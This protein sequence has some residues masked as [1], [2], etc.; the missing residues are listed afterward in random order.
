MRR[1]RGSIEISGEDL[2]ILR[3]VSSTEFISRSQVYRLCC[4]DKPMLTRPNFGWRFRRL[5]THSL[6]AAHISATQLATRSLQLPVT[7]GMFL[8]IRLA[9]SSRKTFLKSKPS[10]AT[11]P[12]M[13]NMRLR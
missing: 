5:V 3:H 13:R 7:A 10:T 1:S 11:H 4:F 9:R 2:A 12:F 8:P 6:L